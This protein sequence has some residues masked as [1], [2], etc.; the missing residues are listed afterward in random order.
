MHN[1]RLPADQDTMD[2]EPSPPD[3]NHHENLAPITTVSCDCPCHE[4]ECSG[5]CDVIDHRCSWQ[6][7]FLGAMTIS[8]TEGAFDK[9]TACKR[10]RQF[11]VLMVS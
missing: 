4:G 3:L 2:I 11:S 7:L 9:E 8:C 6:Q 5:D 1:V 10:H